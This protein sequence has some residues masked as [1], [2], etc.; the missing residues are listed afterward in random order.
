MN[1]PTHGFT[2]LETLVALSIIGLALVS[3][4][5]AVGSTASAAASLREHTL[6]TWV[7]EN[8]LAEIR[9]LGLWPSIGENTGSSEMGGKTYA[10]VQRVSGT[11]NPLFRRV[12]VEVRESESG[13]VISRLSGFA[14][15]PLR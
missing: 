1:R 13:R 2:L 4:M 5:R 10:W 3:A 14:V 8:R 7:A 6:A 15:K 9:A 11:P 12:D